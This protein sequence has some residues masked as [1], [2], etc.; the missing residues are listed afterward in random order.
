MNA[1]GVWDQYVDLFRA[2]RQALNYSEEEN[3]RVLDRFVLMFV[4][5]A[6]TTGL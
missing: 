5:M 3:W 1:T 2:E 4:S 6:F